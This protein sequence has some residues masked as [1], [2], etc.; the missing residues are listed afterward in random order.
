[1]TDPLNHVICLNRY[2]GTSSCPH[3][4]YVY[5]GLL[6][7]KIIILA[8]DIH[9][10]LADYII[11]NNDSD[12]FTNFTIFFYPVELINNISTDL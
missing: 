2:A 4:V 11:Y 6:A 10:V 9:K 7:D 5:T 1:M 3:Y 8:D 12:M